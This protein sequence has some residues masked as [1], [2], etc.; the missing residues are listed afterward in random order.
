MER[1]TKQIMVGGVAIGGGAPLAIQ[2]M[3]NTKTT[4]VEATLCQLHRLKEAGC[5]VARLTVPDE[6]AARAFGRIRRDSPLPLVADI[7]FDYKAAIWA[8]E[9]GADKIRI[10]PGNIG[11][12]EKVGEVVRACRKHNI[13]IRIGVNGGSLE[14]DILAKYGAPTA[15]ALV[16]SAMSHVEKLHRCENQHCRLPADGGK[17]RLSPPSGGHRGGHPVYGH[18]EIGGGLRGA[19]AG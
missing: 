5:H 2:S 6:K 1:K 19:A 7:H 16:E 9:E 18:P 10:N 13:P 4:D 8:A 14:K 12:D 15:E 3:A 11:S 17:D